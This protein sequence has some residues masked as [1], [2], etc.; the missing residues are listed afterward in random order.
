M[1]QTI[2]GYVISEVLCLKIGTEK[3]KK[4]TYSWIAFQLYKLYNID[5]EQIY[6]SAVSEE[7]N[8]QIIDVR[9]RHIGKLTFPKPTTD[10]LLTNRERVYDYDNA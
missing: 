6:F 1:T 9:N 5:I 3:N 10:N 2:F 4:Y 7:V 8:D